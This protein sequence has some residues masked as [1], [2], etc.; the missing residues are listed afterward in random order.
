MLQ[1]SDAREKLDWRTAQ[2]Q[3]SI[4]KKIFAGKSAL[5]GV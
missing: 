5:M 2:P 3:K 4:L 1:R